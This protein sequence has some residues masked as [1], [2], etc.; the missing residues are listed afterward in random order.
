MLDNP[1]FPHSPALNAHVVAMTGPVVPWGQLAHGIQP[2]RAA[3]VCPDNVTACVTNDV[4]WDG[5][6]WRYMTGGAG[7]V[8]QQASATHTWSGMV[9]GIA[10]AAATLVVAA[11]LS[12]AALS[13]GATSLGQSRKLEVRANAGATQGA[14]I[15]TNDFVAGTTGTA[16]FLDFGAGSG[17]TTGKIN[18][19]IAGGSTS[20]TLVLQDVVAGSLAS[21]GTPLG[22]N[23]KLEIRANASSSG[24]VVGTNDYV[25]GTT[26]SSLFFD[27]GAASGNTTSRINAT[28]AG[29]SAAGDL[30][31]QDAISTCRVGVG[32]APS[33]KLHVIGG[34]SVFTAVSEAFAVGA[35]YVST[36]GHVWFGATDSTGTPGFQI[37]NAGGAALISGTN[38]GALTVPGTLGVGGSPS[39]IL[40]LIG[41]NVKPVI[42][43]AAHTVLYTG[44]DGQNNTSLEIAASGSGT[45]VA[46]LALENPNTGSGTS[47]HSIAFS[48]S[49]TAAAEKRLAL[50]TANLDSSGATN[51]SG[52]LVLWTASAGTLGQ[53]ISIN[54]AGCVVI[55]DGSGYTPSTRLDVIPAVGRFGSTDTVMRIVHGVSGGVSVLGFSYYDDGATKNRA[56]IRSFRDIVSSPFEGGLL[57][58]WTGEY[59]A[60][61]MI[62]RGFYRGNSGLRLLSDTSTAGEWL[63]LQRSDGIALAALVNGGSSGNGDLEIQRNAGS[64][65]VRQVVFDRVAGRMYVSGASEAFALGVRYVSTGGPVYFGASDSTATPGFQISSAG[66]ASLISGTNAGAISIPG[67]LVVTGNVTVGNATAASLLIVNG[68]SSGAAGGAGIFAQNGGSGKIGIGNYSFV[69]GGAYD[70]T[71]TLYTAGDL[72]F[73]PGGSSSVSA[74]LTSAGNFNVVGDVAVNVS[75]FTVAA[76]TGN[77]V[78][79]GTLTITGVVNGGGALFTS[80]ADSKGDL[81]TIVQNS[82]SASYTF[83]LGDAG[84]QIYHTSATPHT[85]TIPA[86]ASVA[87]DVGTA[88]TIVNANGGGTLTIAITTDTLRWGGVGSTGSR[89][90]AATG[91]ATVLK[92]TSTEW[93]ITGTGIG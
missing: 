4:Y 14:Q 92:I 8:Y 41:T 32:G 15:G 85:F 44:Y 51:L 10:G 21:I 26:G 82:Q 87:Y 77:T 42:G 81:R 93:L 39:E 88:I 58:F 22:H 86:N 9:A 37:S 69:H 48:C 90:L 57:E 12:A 71:G 62:K 75:K 54:N 34:R 60:G 61:T 30:V 80:V 78:V 79:A 49:A 6:S 74:R 43:K 38:L 73:T 64:G 27:F 91:V 40:S 13:V 70:A 65:L 25:N 67:T 2:G 1:S 55:G 23:R 18:A 3:F 47:F 19:V 76:A 52:N 36:G 16:L 83:V 63:E 89:T 53:R 24:M 5:R 68:T 20:G 56:E 59:T 29:G 7:A 17:N 84:K 33:W 11:V 72:V 45:S 28:T 50:I 66:G 35:Q 46:S 31:L